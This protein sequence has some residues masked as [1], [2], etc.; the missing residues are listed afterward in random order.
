MEL[1][2]VLLI[3]GGFG[4]FIYTR[5]KKSREDKANSLG[6]GSTRTTTSGVKKK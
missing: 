6:G 1:V 5:V 2:V 3:L 4:Y